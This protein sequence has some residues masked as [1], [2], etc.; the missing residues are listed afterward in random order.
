M[1]TTSVDLEVS[2]LQF[3]RSSLM[4]IHRSVAEVLCRYLDQHDPFDYQIR[5]GTIS[6][7]LD[8]L[9]QIGLPL[10][11]SVSGVTHTLD[12]ARERVY[13]FLGR[14]SRAPVACSDD[15]ARALV[16]CGQAGITPSPLNLQRFAW[17]LWELRA[18]LAGVPSDLA[19]M[20]RGALRRLH[21][22]DK[23]IEDTDPDLLLYMAVSTPEHAEVVL[24]RILVGCSVSGFVNVD[25]RDEIRQIYN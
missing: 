18:L 4:H 19:E 10:P 13:R 17:D 9:E 11:T 24:M 3:Q 5:Y 14:L 23:P 20:G 8:V 16:D 6:G 15:I 2:S 1:L 12:S 21:F 7:L 25:L 22:C